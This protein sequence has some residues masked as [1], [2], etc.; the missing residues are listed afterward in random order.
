[1]GWAVVALSAVSAAT[2]W[3]V[4]I[5][6]YNQE[7]VVYPIVVACIFAMQLFWIWLVTRKRQNWAR[8]TN[9]VLV[10]LAIPSEILGFG[11]RFRF[12]AAMTIVSCAALVVWAVAVALLF[13][14]DARGWFA[15]RRLASDAGLPAS[16]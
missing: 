16:S 5:K 14:R 9:L 4:I 12:N 10:V 1:L 3:A 7:P 2:D 6:F 13:R 8:W 11:E 15:D